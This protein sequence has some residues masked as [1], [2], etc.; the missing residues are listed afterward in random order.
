MSDETMV[1]VPPVEAAGDEETYQARYEQL[2]QVL[3]RQGQELGELRRWQQEQL[4]AAAAQDPRVETLAP[5]AQ[6]FFERHLRDGRSHEEALRLAVEDAGALLAMAQ[7]LPSAPA[8]PAGVSLA[9]DVETLLGEAAVPGI[10][11]AELL[12]ELEGVPAEAWG[13]QDRAVR[14]RLVGLLAKAKLAEKMLAGVFDPAGRPPATAP[15]AVNVPGP[16]GERVA[17]ARTL[18]LREQLRSIHPT[19]T[20]EQ[21]D[22]AIARAA[23]RGG[24]G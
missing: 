14:Q 18:A 1:E 8:A 19:L 21:L 10:A 15:P 9:H 6:T 22:A 24:V 2:Q 5:A 13:A 3:G 11:A 16:R 23:H 17:D 12:P 7:T 4:A 20:D